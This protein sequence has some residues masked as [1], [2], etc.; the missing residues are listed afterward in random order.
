[1]RNWK[2]VMHTTKKG[3]IWNILI[4]SK[5]KK[6]LNTIENRQNIQIGKKEWKYKCL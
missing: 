5:N 6:S 1:M 3:S 2:Y 4:S